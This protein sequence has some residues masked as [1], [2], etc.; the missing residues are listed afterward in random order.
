MILFPGDGEYLYNC[1]NYI[2]IR[3]ENAF[4]ICGEHFLFEVFK[5]EIFNDNVTMN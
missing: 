1:L 5:H 3:V 4:Y 2:N